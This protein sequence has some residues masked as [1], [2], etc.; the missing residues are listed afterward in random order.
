MLCI[1]RKH[2]ELSQRYRLKQKGQRET[3]LAMLDFSYATY[4]MHKSTDALFAF[5]FPK[6]TNL[7]VPESNS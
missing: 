1:S 7:L 6:D 3:E 2:I 4:I 5:A